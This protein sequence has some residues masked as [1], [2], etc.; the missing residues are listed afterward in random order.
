MA[1]NTNFN[2]NPYYDDFD[3]DKLFLRLLFKPGFAVQAR[4]LTQLQTLLQNQVGRFG[5]HVF[6]NGSL[7]TGGQTTIQNA[8]YLNLSSAFAETTVDV[9]TFEGKTIVDNTTNPS[10]RAEVLKVYESNPTTGEPK[11]LI[12]QQIFGEPFTSTET[13]RTVEDNPVFANVAPSGVGSSQVYSVNE[14]VFYYEG[15]F[16][17][18]LPQIV[19]LTKY[20]S[21]GANV[22]VGF[23]ISESLINASQDT[24]LLDPAQNASNYQAPGADRYKI[25]LTLATR[26]IDSVDTTEFIELAQVEN[27][28][29]IKEGKYPLYSVLE[30]TLARRTYDESGNYTVKPFKLSLE[31]SAANSAQANVILSPGKAYIYGFEFETL[32]PTV[33]TF[34]KPRTTE[35]VANKRIAADYGAYV[36]ANTIHGSPPIGGSDLVDLH[37]VSNTDILRT[38]SA[39]I[40]NTKIGTA[41]IK[42]IAFDSSANTANANTFIYRSYVFDVNV[43]NVVTGF[44][45]NTINVTTIQIANRLTNFFSNVNNAYAGARFR[46]TT[47]PGSNE[48]AKT[49]INYNGATQTV[50]LSEPFLTAPIA[51]NTGAA[52]N[53]S[54]SAWSID[55]DF[56]DTRSMVV[57][58]STPTNRPIFAINIDQRSKD[59]GSQFGDIVIADSALEALIFPLGEEYIA[60][61]SITDFVYSYKKLF[62]GSGTGQT[63]DATG[64]AT[65]TVDTGEALAS[66]GS[67]VAELDNYTVIVTDRTGTGYFAGQV[68]PPNL[69]SITGNELTVTGAGSSFKANII[70]TIDVSTSSQR[71]KSLIPAAQNVASA[72]GTDIFN[73]FGNGSVMLFST[74]GQVHIS[75]NTVVKTPGTPQ[76]IFV[77]DVI[78]INSIFDFGNTAI[79]TANLATAINVTNR[80]VLDS[81]QKDSF[82]D[83]GSIKLKSGQNP[84]TG[85]LL[86][87][88]D[89]YS[90]TGTGY[91]TVS[92]YPD[93]GDIPVYSSQYGVSYF[94]RDSLDFR[95]VR[96]PATTTVRAN[97]VIFDTSNK[98][99]VIGSNI[100][101][102]YQ[103][104]LPR[105]DKIIL[106]KDKTFEVVKGTPGLNPVEPPNKNGSMTLY[107]LREAPF[108]TTTDEI[109]VQYIDHKRYTMRD[110]GAM[111][112]RLENLEYYTSL[113]LLEQETLN[114]QDLS[115]R[116][117]NG[118]Q[119]FKNGIIVDSFQG[120]SVADVVR[121]DYRA[122]IDIRNND[123]HPSFNITN[124]IISF[125]S[126]NS[127]SYTKGG[128][129][130][131]LE[132]TPVPFIEQ[133]KASKS[134]NINPFSVI[135]YL[136]KIDLDPKTDIWYD[137]NR[138]ADV[139]VNIGGDKDAW[140]Q[141]LA[142]LPTATQIEWNS[143]ENVWTGSST[144]NQRGTGAFVRRRGIEIF[145]V[146]TTT[147]RTGQIREGIASTLG[148]ETITQSI[149]DRI[150]DVS[151]IPYM[152]DRNVL[153]VGSSFKPDTTL[154]SFFDN[155]NASKY[156][157]KANRFILAQ[158][159]LAYNTEIGNAET[160]NIFNNITNTVNGTCI[161]VK[162]SNDSIFTVSS[163]PV[164]A[165]NMANANLVGIS[166]GTTVRIN[167]YEHFTGN[168]NASTVG[169]I[170]LRIDATGSNNEVLYANTTNSNTIFIVAGVGAGQERTMN[171]YNAVTRT[172][173]V[174]VNWSTPPD[175]TSVYTIGTP[176]SSAA[177]DVAGIFFIPNGVYR[178]GEKRFRLIDNQTGDLGS[179]G[180]NGD[181]SF[182]SQGLIQTTEETIISA[183]VPTITR[184]SVVDERVVTTQTTTRTVTG[185]FDPLAQTFLISPVN[186]P[187]G[188]FIDRVRLCFKTKDDVIPVTLQLRPSVNG[189]PSSSVI[190]PFGSVTLTADKVKITDSPDFDDA[191]KYTDFIFDAPIYMQPGEQSFVLLANS[192]KYEVFIAEVGG[193][194]IATN[195]QISE[196]PYGGSL[197]LSQNGSTWTADQNSDMMFKIFRSQFATTGTVFFNVNP[198]STNTAYD[199][200]HLIISDLSV[201]NTAIS[202]SFRSEKSAGGGLT[203]F[204]TIVPLT[205]YQMNDGDGRR[206]LNPTTSNNTFVVRATLST[207]NSE[208]SP[209]IDT[210]RMGLLAIENIINDMPLVNST[211]I[212]ANT[213]SNMQNGIYQLS[214]SGGGGSG[215]TVLANVVGGEISTAF[216]TNG[217]SGYTTT[218]TINLFASTAISA[219]GYVG[220]MCVGTS[221]NGASI[222]IN[223]EDKKIGGNGNVRYIT[224]RVTL[225]DSFESGDLRVYLT[226]YRPAGSG[227][228]VYYKILSGSDTDNFENKEYQLMTE[229]DNE[230]FVSTNEQDYR[231]F[232]FA[233]GILNQA[234]NSVT[235]TT[236][237][238]THDKFKTFT[239]KIVMSGTD[240]TDVPKIRD[241]RSIALPRG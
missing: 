199:L 88:F 157:A 65:L 96:L 70:A 38:T 46:I 28:I 75:S 202:Y 29:L 73:V 220:A 109:T 95:L 179:S 32:S 111:D 120:H 208:I 193:L 86:V 148:L 7:V 191:S 13:I 49:I 1:I 102:D 230:N 205:N 24:S 74:I 146:S 51:A 41:R 140:D 237:S 108:L 17:R 77:S 2:V 184:A 158:N 133:N 47:G 37:C 222:L 143:W 83:H 189:F 217:G 206:V 26:A 8:A 130:V 27:S 170:T 162:T 201:T 134:I 122:S 132:S 34:D 185:Y 200:A 204:K 239:I 128:P 57:N 85:N 42:S 61:N 3:E 25:T 40:S 240:T 66:A 97:T 35:S 112:K 91:F 56:N 12:I 156:V 103:Y 186:Y 18:N 235:Y 171:A 197:F 150:V 79:T 174:S 164:T 175:S 207:F 72:T 62:S 187:Q 183:T 228:N 110:I 155:E 229:L 213:G 195:Q 167:G 64:K 11:T 10:K 168:A 176:R 135:N 114:K 87:R 33:I 15:F 159:D 101:L 52:A 92:S 221:S 161:V 78:R 116:D 131:T 39:K 36:Y 23:E 21:T 54:A 93:Y 177:G 141:I 218:P 71:N 31:T 173:N 144:N 68:L 151:I 152:R 194:D 223:G 98:I 219:Y 225:G 211:I 67:I 82:Y 55:F 100:D 118:L 20:T 234:N 145:N 137:I 227:I 138:K 172:A 231:E 139:L 6:K 107:I 50:T 63:F 153:F 136:G 190:Y 214:L 125:D 124:H 149:G 182:F 196:Q 80:Y 238:T 14:G 90:S 236:G 115:I 30:D 19:A 113:S 48:P 154:F 94:L 105:I 178:V 165:F 43:S 160:A 4:E 232:T 166:T 81:G 16:I 99:P 53:S 224:R 192:K 22:R 212:L 5:N 215:A 241:F 181:A 127:S 180:T 209:V 203:N 169:S 129:Y 188:I 142:G 147:T 84:P 69:Y 44:V 104:F 60:N 198:P 45:N 58:A 106:N 123:L 121:E 119:R 9:G 126:A 216:V 117:A 89:S 233:P 210:S 76:Q 59:S 226:A 163:N